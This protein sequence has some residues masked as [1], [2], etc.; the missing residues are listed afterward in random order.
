[1][2]DRSR[3][4]RIVRGARNVTETDRLDDVAEAGHALARAFDNLGRAMCCLAVKQ[5]ARNP[6]EHRELAAILWQDVINDFREVATSEE[7]RNWMA[8]LLH[9]DPRNMPKR[10]YGK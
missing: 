4:A 2:S 10:P 9:I 5:E 8:G 7:M 3:K 6:G 1:M